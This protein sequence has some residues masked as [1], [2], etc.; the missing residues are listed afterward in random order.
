MKEPGQ[1]DIPML[2]A[3]AQVVE[4]PFHSDVP[5]LGPLIARLR[6]LWNSVATKWYVRPLLQQQNDFNLAVAQRM[7]VI[8]EYVFEHS[9][10]QDRELVRL[11]RETAELQ[12]VAAHLKEVVQALDQQLAQIEAAAAHDDV[13]ADGA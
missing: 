4:R 13:G 9:T 2:L 7:E 11:Q 1:T 5:L 8:E 10:T 3:K 6:G 12:L